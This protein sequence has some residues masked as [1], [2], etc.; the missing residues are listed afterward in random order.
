VLLDRDFGLISGWTGLATISLI[1]GSAQLMTL[2]MLGE[3][4]GRL[5]M[6][7][8]RRPLFVMSEVL[9]QQTEATAMV[10][11]ALAALRHWPVA[12]PVAH[13]NFAARSSGIGARSYLDIVQGSW[14]R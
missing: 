1:I 12:G 2:G 5:Y 10:T 9:S 13:P 4:I 7:S 14:T 11:D 8:K 3:Y 6:E